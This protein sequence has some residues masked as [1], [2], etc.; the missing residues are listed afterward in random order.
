MLGHAAARQLQACKE[1]HGCGG[2]GYFLMSF[3]DGTGT[4]LASCE[5]C[6][7]G[8]DNQTSER[9]KMIPFSTASRNGYQRK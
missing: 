8:R 2:R 6:D 1:N 3:L 9:I 4:W 7:L 5:Q